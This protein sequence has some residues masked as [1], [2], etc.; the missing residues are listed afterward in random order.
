MT[1]L[2]D[3]YVFALCTSRIY[4]PE[5][6]ESVKAFMKEAKKRGFAVLVF[7]SGLDRAGS[8]N[9]ASCFSV[10]DLIPFRIVDMV[11]VMA[12]TI[13]NQIV[14]ESIVQR[15]REHHIPVMSYD[16]RMDG[17]PSV[18]SYSNLAFDDLLEHILTVH[19]CRKVNLMSGIRGNYGSECMTNSYRE[20]LRRHGIPYE[21]NRVGYGD[22]WEDPAAEVCERFLLHDTPDAIVCINDS[23]AIAVCAVLNRHGLRVPEDVIVTGSDGIVKERFHTPR[24]TTCVKD[25]KRL[26][27]VTFDTAELM[28]DGEEVDLNID[29]KPILRISESCGCYMTEQRD[30]NEAIR[31]LSRKLDI[32]VNQESEEHWILGS[33]LERKQLTVI[34]YLDVISAHIPED[35]YLCLRDCISAEISS[36]SLRQFADPSELMST[37]M[38]RRKEKQFAMIPRAQLIPDLDKILASGRTVFINVIH[39]MNEVYGYYAYYGF[40]IEDE[41]F[42]L[43]KFIHTAGNVIGSNLANSRLQAM[44]ERLVAARIRDS[45]TG[46]YNLHGALKTLAER[47]RG[48]HP[49]H[50]HLVLIVIGLNRLRQINS[51][52]G[53]NEGDQALLSLA[54]AITDSVDSDVVS[55]RIGGDEFLIAFFTTPQQGDTAEALISV[56]QKRL[57]SYNQV[58]GKSYSL[59]IS[60]GQVCA[61]IESG[62]SVDSMLNEAIT[63]KDA[64]R[65]GQPD[66]A[67]AK[68]AM[69]D[70]EIAQMERIL[71]ENL[72][73]YHF[74]PIVSAKNGQIYAYE[75]LMRTSGGFRISPLTLL[76]YATDTG[77]LYEIEWLTYNNVLKT[78]YENQKAFEGKRI[79]INSIPGHFL[80]ESDFAKL[81]EA[82]GSLLPQFVVE[83]TEQAETEGEELREIQERCISNQMDIAVDDY[84]TGYSNV[85]NLLKYSP[86]YVKID[87]SLITNIQEE[88]KKQH[89][90]TNIIEFAHANGFMALAE[91]VETAEELRAVIRFGVDLI[92]GNFTSLPNAAPLD[93]IP[94][95]ISALISKFSVSAAKQIMQKTYMPA[96]DEQVVHLRKLELEHYTDMFVAQEEMEI[97]GSFGEAS[98][99]HIRI[100][101]DSDCRLVLRNVHFNTPQQ[102]PAIILGKNSR[103]S[104]EFQ[105]DNRMDVGGI[106]VPE[107]SKL[108]ITGKGNLSIRADDIKAFAI[109]NDPDFACGEIMID[110]AGCL[111]IISNG[112]Q[113]IG[114][115]A[116][117]GRGQRISITGTKV[118]IQMSG[119][120]GVGIG[121][122]DGTSDISLSG[123]EADFDLRMATSVAIGA[124]EGKPHIL[125][126]TACINV[127]GSGTSISCIGSETGGA[128]ITLRDSTIIAKMLGQRISVIGSGDSTPRIGLRQCMLDLRIEGTQALDIGSFKQDAELTIVDTDFNI[129]IQSA[130]AVH[131]GADPSHCI[132]TGGK[133]QVV[134]NE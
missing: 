133:D 65:L 128:D 48:E 24:L 21:E 93:A 61:P 68:P 31:L 4:N 123:C 49:A 58:S 45:L 18:Y 22:Y 121:T 1:V 53:R 97:I 106:L 40:A 28:L 12:E 38:H 15:A 89:F 90:V 63:L 111:N 8:R 75:A 35:S 124:H 69:S 78:V 77:R 39:M 42:K 82:Y 115:G 32:A 134:I 122:L 44:N 76:S 57:V 7:N 130:N 62:I 126:N 92:Q 3:R 119:K 16:G 9:D 67:D 83:F 55:A 64:Q 95:R 118:F 41:C 84:G 30:P 96:S 47:L 88:P 86:N 105:G 103:V 20:A 74:Q 27:T 109:G 71:N 102:A 79:F 70:A 107:S 81:K 46:M 112:N 26:T 85:T 11:F 6:L 110:L 108:H 66:S 56:L 29:V 36:N 33:M 60:V 13:Q 99:L 131:L 87:R 114:I 51:I 50:S 72:L 34:D 120:D 127:E 100:R 125:C 17:V 101:D 132:H 19:Q 5:I 59:E 91:G 113:C 52:F 104:L 10:C 54:S 14:S 129:A 2:N 80:S 94:D 73:T 23:M 116:G 25:Y 37:V 43:P 117:I 98:G